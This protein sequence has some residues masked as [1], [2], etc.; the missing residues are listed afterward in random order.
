[1]LLIL[2]QN[3]L[4]ICCKTN[5]VD[6]VDTVDT[7]DTVKLAS[8]TSSSITNRTTHGSNTFE[9]MAHYLRT[10]Y[11]L[12]VRSVWFRLHTFKEVNSQTS[13]YNQ[14]GEYG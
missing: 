8:C 3:T 13:L 7:V 10:P 9:L 2:Q 14:A 12:C 1:M 6:S 11:K 4:I 5:V